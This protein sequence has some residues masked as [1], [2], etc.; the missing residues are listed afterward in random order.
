[1]VEGKNKEPHVSH[2]MGK[3]LSLRREIQ[4]QREA[5]LAEVCLHDKVLSL[6]C[7]GSY[8]SINSTLNFVPRFNGEVNLFPLG[9]YITSLSSFY[10]WFQY[11]ILFFNITFI[12]ALLR[13]NLHIR[14][15]AHFKYTNLSI[16]IQ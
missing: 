13:Y 11:I 12:F 14:N 16:Q 6:F 15:F 1:M 9:S 10:F 4:P 8:L 7:S 2:M 5:D 3:W